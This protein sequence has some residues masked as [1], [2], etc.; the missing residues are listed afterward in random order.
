MKARAA[1]DVDEQSRRRLRRLRR[2]VGSETSEKERIK[3][4]YRVGSAGGVSFG[5]EA[6]LNVF[7]S[8]IKLGEESTVS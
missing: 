6:S 4:R 5:N 7:I 2:R 8:T 1:D 3:R